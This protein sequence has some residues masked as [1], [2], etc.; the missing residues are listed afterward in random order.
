MNSAF[1]L[2]Y[3]FI[4]IFGLIIGSFLSVVI[5]RYPEMLHQQWQTEC[6]EFLSLKTET[7]QDKISLALPP[8]HCPQCKMKLKF[9]HNIPLF[10]YLGLGGKCAYCKRP[11]SLLYPV[12]EL[13]TSLLTVITLWHFGLTWLGFAA[14]L[15]TYLMIVLCFID[16]R[17]QLLP[18]TITLGTLWIGLI[19]NC[20]SLFTSL[21]SAVLAVVI[22]YLLLWMTAW[23]FS[24]IRHKQGMGHGD[25]KMLAAVG[26]WLGLFNMLHTLLLAVFMGILIS[27]LLITLK[28]VTWHRPIPFGPFIALAAWITLLTGPFIISW[29]QVTS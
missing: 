13:L 26:A 17:H 22:G 11:V 9:Y 23:L 24:L 8:S 15:F 3:L 2:I 18:D 19:F 21:H 1:I 16:L 29:L 10:S 6:R 28:R 14:V 25:F 20:F 5:T 7:P 12:I 27:V 4:A